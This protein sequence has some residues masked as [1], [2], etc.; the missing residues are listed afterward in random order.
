MLIR[1]KVSQSD[2]GHMIGAARENVNR[3]LTD[4]RR[5]RLLSRISGY[6]CLERPAEFED[7]AR[8]E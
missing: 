6:Y 1:Q 5:S 4:W 8:R 3:Q 7:I 2:L